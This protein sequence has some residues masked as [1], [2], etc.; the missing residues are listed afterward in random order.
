MSL[1]EV[2]HALGDRPPVLL[3][4]DAQKAARMARVARACAPGVALSLGD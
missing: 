3:I 1:L 2:R 4:E